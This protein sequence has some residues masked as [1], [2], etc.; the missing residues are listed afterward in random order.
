VGRELKGQTLGLVGFGQIAR[1]LASFAEVIGLDVVAYDPFA[2][3]AAF[4][5][6]RRVH[7]IDELLSMSDIVSL[8]TP[9]LPSTRNLMSAE[10]LTKMKSGALLINTARGEIVD[11]EA[12]ADALESGQLG[13]AGLDSFVTEP[14]AKS[15]L[16]SMVNV[17]MTPHVAGVTADAKSAI[18]R[19]SAENAS[20]FL[21][22]AQIDAKY[23]VVPNRDVASAAGGRLV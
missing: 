15:R 17:I 9:L 6:V 19:I 22:G 16:W 4:T 5:S 1:L 13:G 23:V 18:S 8:H 12:L 14:P 10:R 3:D 11:E 20:A 7:D 2:P 21:E